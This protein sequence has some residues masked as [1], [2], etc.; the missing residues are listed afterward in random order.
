MVNFFSF[1]FVAL[2]DEINSVS[3]LFPA[4]VALYDRII[5]V[6]PALLLYSFVHLLSTKIFCPHGL[7]DFS[8][9]SCGLNFQPTAN[10]LNFGGVG[11]LS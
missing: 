11:N 7:G 10:L 2:Y 1:P 6:S 4:A 9:C 5:R 8:R 3:F